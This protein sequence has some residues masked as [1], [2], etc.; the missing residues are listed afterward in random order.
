MVS[1]ISGTAEVITMDENLGVTTEVETSRVHI[2]GPGI[3]Q[4]ILNPEYHPA[5]IVMEQ[6]ENLATNLYQQPREQ[7]K[8]VETLKEEN[9]LL[10]A[11]LKGFEALGKY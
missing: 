1:V 5:T 3:G 11:K 10:K 8:L 6:L 2:E 7:E 4:C 9:R